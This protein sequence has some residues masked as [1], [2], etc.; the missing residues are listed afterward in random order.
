MPKNII[1]EAVYM[2]FIQ[3]RNRKIIYL[4]MI[5]VCF[6]AVYAVYFI[7]LQQLSA[8]E[9]F[10]SDLF[11]RLR[12]Y[13]KSREIISPS[14]RMISIDEKDIEILNI[15]KNDRTVF[16]Q[17]IDIL[18]TALPAVIVMD[19]IFR[20]NSGADGNRELVE[21]TQKA[22]NVFYPVYLS[23]KDPEG[24][25]NDR[26]WQ[27]IREKTELDIRTLQSK[28][29]PA[30]YNME[31]YPFKNLSRAAAGLGDISL[32]SVPGRRV[33][34]VPLISSFH[35]ALMPSLVLIPVCRFF[36]VS[37]GNI[38]FHSGKYIKLINAGLPEG[39]R[40]DIYIPVD[41]EGR[42]MINFTGQ[43]L[44]HHFSQSVC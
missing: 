38:E 41:S 29:I 21:N 4:L 33:M 14:L 16:G 8:D 7:F 26:S 28:K 39:E 34:R 31:S 2:K 42:M 10:V 22:G 15:K 9:P 25:I 17:M 35:D 3:L 23:D 18:S 24:L 43:T 37:R 13:M 6:A 12:Y 5:S 44:L 19:I 30:R 32:P 20:E 36:N 1:S 27:A 11:Y 40:R